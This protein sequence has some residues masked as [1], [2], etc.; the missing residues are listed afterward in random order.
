M[1]PTT[2][3]NKM[4]HRNN[5]ADTLMNLSRE[6]FYKADFD[7]AIRLRRKAIAVRAWAKRYSNRLDSYIYSEPQ[8]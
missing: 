7:K 8:I 2:L 5:K 6:A 3:L 1:K 4:N